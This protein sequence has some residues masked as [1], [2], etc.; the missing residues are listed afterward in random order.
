[1]NK[2]PQRRERR[3]KKRVRRTKKQI[4]WAKLPELG[5]REYTIRS[6]QQYGEWDIW[7]CNVASVDYIGVAYGSAA[8]GH[9]A[10]WQMAATAEEARAIA[11]ALLLEGK[12]QRYER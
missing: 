11:V 6:Y 10:D 3:E 1:M 12:A 2:V 9:N 5:F 7:A 8:T 4:E